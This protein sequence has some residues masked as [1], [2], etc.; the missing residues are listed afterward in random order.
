MKAASVLFNPVTLVAG[1]GQA[2]SSVDTN[3][4][5]TLSQLNAPTGVAVDPAG[6]LYRIAD[7]TNDAIRLVNSATGQISTIVGILGSSGAGSTAGS[8]VAVQLNAPTAVAVAPNGSL[9]ILDSGNSRVVLDARAAVSFNFGRVN[10]PTASP[11]Q[12]FTELNIGV[13]PA[14]LASPVFTA[15]GDTTQFTLTPAANSSG[16][17]PACSGTRSGSRRDLQYPGTIHPHGG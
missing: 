13:A 7:T 12:N 9:T 15:T 16:T 8:A 11:V 6:N 10:V 14:T 5:A 2:G 17:I 1:N 4:T 3:S